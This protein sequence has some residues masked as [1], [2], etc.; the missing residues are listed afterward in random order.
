MNKTLAVCLLLFW[1][2][3]AGAQERTTTMTLQE[4][5]QRALDRNP[6]IAQARLGSQAASL[7]IAEG[8]AAYSPVFSASLTQRSQSSPATTQLAGGQQQVTT[9]AA[10]YSSGVSQALPWGGGSLSVDFTGNRTATS[11]VFSTFNPSLTS[12]LTT[13]LTQPLLRG[14]RFDST[15]AAIE[16]ATIGSD[17]AD[18]ELRQELAATR[19]KVR[20]AYW[21]LVYAADARTTAQR[22]EAR[23]GSSKRTVCASSSAPSRQST[24]SSPRQRWRRGT[25]P[26]F[27]RKGRGARRR[28]H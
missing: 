9:N 20:R 5:E 25:R 17:I 1:S 24:S 3:P 18:V 21:E 13:A 26:S 4:A 22:S 27:R 19:A 11:N 23:N 2:V 12:G 16:Q 7:T 10:S 14:F 8:R 28:W 6:A 15:R